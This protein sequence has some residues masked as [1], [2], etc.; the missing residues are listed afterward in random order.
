MA[1]S[2]TDFKRR[3]KLKRRARGKAQEILQPYHQ[4]ILRAPQVKWYNQS[5]R[6]P[7]FNKKLFQAKI[8][9]H[10]LL[11]PPSGS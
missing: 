5:F 4:Q 11:L 10:G 2:R 3:K 1:E 8:E 7:K 6:K 9:K